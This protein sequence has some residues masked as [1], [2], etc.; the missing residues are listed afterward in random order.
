MKAI[1]SVN[2]DITIECL[3]PDFKGQWNSLQKV[4][5]AK[6]EIISH[7]L[8]TV[9]RLSKEIRIFASYDLSL[10][11]IKKISE[12]GITS[13]SGIMVGLGETEDEIV[14]TMKD[15]FSVGCKIFTIGQYLQPTK[16]NYPVRKYVSPQEFATYK[17][18]GLQIGFKFVESGPLVR[19]SYHAELHV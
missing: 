19:S 3:V 5:D 6:P 16:Q 18:I 13:K 11:V 7:N 9:K 17:K 12:S 2:T 14:T 8:E 10:Q 1:K 15:L 4:I